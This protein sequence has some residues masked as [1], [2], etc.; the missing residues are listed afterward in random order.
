M[1]Q[2]SLHGLAL[3]ENAICRIKDLKLITIMEVRRSRHVRR[4][5]YQ[6]RMRTRFRPAFVI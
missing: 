6:E 1:Q 5:I 2:R 3:V 4:E